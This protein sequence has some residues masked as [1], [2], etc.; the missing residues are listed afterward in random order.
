[1]EIEG[2]AMSRRGGDVNGGFT[3][4]T[5]DSVEDVAAWYAEELEDLGLAETGRSDNRAGN[6]RLLN[7]GFEGEGRSVNT[8]ITADDGRTRTVVSYSEEGE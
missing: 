6:T 3:F 2:T 4:E 8:M 1:V 5:D 7:L